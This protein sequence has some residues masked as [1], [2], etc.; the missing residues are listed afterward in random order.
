MDKKLLNALMKNHNGTLSKLYDLVDEKSRK[1]FNKNLADEEG[2]RSFS[3]DEKLEYLF[4]EN[5]CRQ[6]PEQ[7][8]VQAIE[9]IRPLYEDQQRLVAT[10]ASRG[11]DREYRDLRIWSRVPTIWYARADWSSNSEYGLFET[12]TNSSFIEDLIRQGIIK[13]VQDTLLVTFASFPN[14][15]CATY[16]VPFKKD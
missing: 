5:L 7:K 11:P 14:T 12:D 15:R 16:E 10:S 4:E 8:V 2:F 13:Q 3:H 9:I 6:I 1:R